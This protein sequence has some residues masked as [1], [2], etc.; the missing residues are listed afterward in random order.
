VG[1]EVNWALVKNHNPSPGSKVWGKISKA[2]KWMVEKLD[3]PP[4]QPVE[5][6]KRASIWWG[7]NFRGLE[8]RLSIFRIQKLYKSSLH[9]LGDLWK[10]ETKDFHS[11]D[12]LKILFPLEDMEY[13]CWQWLINNLLEC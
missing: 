1:P 12:E 9:T 5:A 7:S 6:I 2:W 11:W 3:F 4:L 10:V 13:S 8:F